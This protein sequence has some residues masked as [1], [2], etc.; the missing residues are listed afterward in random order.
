MSCVVIPYILVA[1]MLMYYNYIRFSSPFDFGANYN[2][3]SNDMTLRGFKLDRIGLGII[4]YLVQPCDI[5]TQFPFLSVIERRPLYMGRTIWENTFG[6]CLFLN[7][8]L[9]LSAGL[10]FVRKKIQKSRLFYAMIYLSVASLVVVVADTEMAGILERYQ[11]DF[12]WMLVLV[13]SY[14]VLNLFLFSA[15]NIEVKSWLVHIMVILLF[16][17]VGLQFL[18][19]FVGSTI[20]LEEANPELYFKMYYLIQFWV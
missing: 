7:P 18:Q 15:E 20:T 17:G 13:S 14:V 11:A 19:L 2:L 12:L 9:F 4:Q 1:G 16:T 5:S 3:T 8:L 10:W 6:G